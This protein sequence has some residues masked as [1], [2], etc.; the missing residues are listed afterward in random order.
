MVALSFE[1]L[2]AQLQSPESMPLKTLQ[3]CLIQNNAFE[4]TNYRPTDYSGTT[5]ILIV[6]HSDREHKAV[7]HKIWEC[8]CQLT[9]A[10]G[11]SPNACL[12]LALQVLNKLPIIPI[13][14]TFSTQIPMIMGYCPES[15]VY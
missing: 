14:L 12:G 11:A 2:C 8:I 3:S 7:E 9:D 1:H 5:T 13:D 15:C 6:F 4:P 10:E